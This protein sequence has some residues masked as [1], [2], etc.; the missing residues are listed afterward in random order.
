M[1][2]ANMS[3]EPG[4]DVDQA[5]RSLLCLV[6]LAIVIHP[7]MLRDG[8]VNRIFNLYSNSSAFDT[9][10]RFPF[11]ILYEKSCSGQ[12]EHMNNIYYYFLFI[13]D[14]IQVSFWS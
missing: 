10:E 13:H 8:T 11:I 7:Q 4:N 14:F 1:M 2:L 6:L 5:N 3:E 12:Q 9:S